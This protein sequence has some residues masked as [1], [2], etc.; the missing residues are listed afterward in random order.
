V[1]RYAPTRACPALPRARGERGKAVNRRRLSPLTFIPACIIFGVSPALAQAPAAPGKL[2]PEQVLLTPPPLGG[3]VENVSGEYQ[4]KLVNHDAS[5]SFQGLARVSFGGGGERLAGAKIHVALGPRD[6]ATFLLYSLPAAGDQYTLT[7]TDAAGRVVLHK[8]AHA[9]KVTDISLADALPTLGVRLPNTAAPLDREIK[10]GAR[11]TGGETED[12]PFVLVLEVESPQPIP[13][14][15]VT[16][17]AKGFQQSTRVRVEG[18]TQ[19]EFKLPDELEAQ[20]LASTLADAAGRVVARGEADIDRLLSDQHVT[21]G[22]FSTDRPTYKP[23]DVA[24]LKVGV[25]GGARAKYQVEITAKDGRGTVFFRDSRR[26]G[27]REQAGAAQEFAVTLPRDAPGPVRVEIK[28]L[29][30]ESGETVDSTE[31]EIAL[32]EGGNQQ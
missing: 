18:H 10:I 12:E 7:I 29:D 15:K 14:A 27:G 31:R 13:D 6:G 1:L 8:I 20:K 19:V 23:G 28:L 22:E 4:L 3:V 25:R 2:Q 21:V 9:R 11:L 32:G 30:A 24:Q 26:G 17:T 16:V 5:R